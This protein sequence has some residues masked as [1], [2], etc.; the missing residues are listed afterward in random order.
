MK[1]FPGTD[2]D[3]VI[4][5]HVYN[6]FD[7][8]SY[9]RTFQEYS[10]CSYVVVDGTIRSQYHH[11]LEEAEKTAFETAQKLIAKRAVKNEQQ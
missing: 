8:D 3:D 9:D 1:G 2:P 6:C 5:I 11:T 7:P 10:Y 4:F